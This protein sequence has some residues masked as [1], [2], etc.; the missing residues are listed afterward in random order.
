MK[1]YFPHNVVSSI[2]EPLDADNE[3]VFL[4]R[5]FCALE[6][7]MGDNFANFIFV[8]HRRVRGEFSGQ[9]IRLDP[10]GSN[11]VLIVIADEKEVFPYEEFRSYRWIFHSY[12]NP[13][14]GA[15][16]IHPF[17]VGYL[18]AA[19]NVAAIPFEDRQT[20]LFF[21]GYLNKNRVDL[22]KQFRDIR[23]LPHRNLPHNKYLREIARRAVDKLVP[24][25]NFDNMVPGARL[26]FTEAF[27]KGL[28]PNE[29]ARLLA[30]SK[31]AICPPGFVSNE[32]IRH[33][34]A[35]RLG[36]VVI[37]APLPPNRFYEGSP[38]I[39][40]DDWSALL[41]TVNGLLSKPEK[42]RDLHAATV[43]WWNRVCSEEAMA[44]YMEGVIESG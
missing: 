23:W 36:C 15:S 42:L 37:S 1:P 20:P 10:G 16:R 17:P 13:A 32:T 19:G 34:E 21:S 40:L 27:A 12:G 38:I 30:D 43:E 39:Q 28:P 24:E 25:R 11:R 5:L 31:I 18:N 33:W 8:V 29:Y 35:M 9:P 7:R 44:E 14:G 6:A 41:P 2:G 4:H 22:L 26:G 3:A